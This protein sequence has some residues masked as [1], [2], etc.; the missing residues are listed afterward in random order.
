M[1][2]DGGRQVGGRYEAM[3]AGL[4]RRGEGAFVPFFVLGDPDL[5]TS[6]RLLR[7]AVEA[8][9]DALELGIP[10]SD[11]IADGPVLQRAS[12]R[13]AAS[14]ATPQACFEL[15][16]SIRGALGDTPAGLLT[17]ANLVVG[18]GVE[19][20]YRRAAEAGIDSVLVADIPLLEA[21]PFARAAR[22]HGVAPIL[23]APPNLP[24]ERVAG[25]AELSAGYTYCVARKGVTGA[26]EGGGASHTSLFAALRAA[27][28]PPPLLGFGISTP[29]HVRAAVESGAA[30]AISGSAVAQLIEDSRGDREGAITAVQA[31]IRRMK[32]ATMP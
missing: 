13:A 18:G 21:A 19:A 5:E 16:A 29:A 23:L 10:F 2:D 17:Y 14:G 24:A 31:F 25:I 32:A 15:L 4:G 3:F 8:G 12:L 11:P 20:F 27:G 30:G 6:A 7:A 28:A 1:K 22:D 9:A 26:K